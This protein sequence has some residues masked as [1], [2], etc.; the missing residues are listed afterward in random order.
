M[1]QRLSDCTA[2]SVS[3]LLS[4]SVCACLGS[5]GEQRSALLGAGF[6]RYT[7]LSSVQRSTA[8]SAEGVSVYS[9]M[10]LLMAIRL[11]GACGVCV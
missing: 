10:R 2:A 6:F 1:K 3:D 4:R 11:W 7:S 9:S 8:S 5:R